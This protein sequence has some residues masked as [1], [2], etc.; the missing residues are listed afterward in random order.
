MTGRLDRDDGAC[1][2]MDVSKTLKAEAHEVSSKCELAAEIED[3]HV[4]HCEPC[5]TTCCIVQAAHT[6]DGEE[7]IDAYAQ[8]PYDRARGGNRSNI[9]VPSHKIRESRDTCEAEERLPRE[10]LLQ[11]ACQSKAEEDDEDASDAQGVHF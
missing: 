10:V 11:N 5:Q 9:S 4:R 1:G 2:K 8:H 7:D 3:D 6:I